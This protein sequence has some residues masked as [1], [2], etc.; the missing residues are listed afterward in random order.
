[1][2]ITDTKQVPFIDRIDELEI[3]NRTFQDWDSCYTVF[4]QGEGG[5]GKTRFVREAVQR[6]RDRLGSSLSVS[7]EEQ[8]IRIGT[9]ALTG[10]TGWG[11]LFL[12]GCREMAKDLGVQLIERDAKNDLN[13]MTIC[14][15]SLMQEHPQAVIIDLGRGA[16]LQEA[17]NKAIRQGIHVITV[18]SDLAGDQLVEIAQNEMQMALHS[19][20]PMI[21]DLDGEGNILVCWNPG[22]APLE[23]RRKMLDEV[24]KRYPKIRI[25]AEI[26]LRAGGK[27][28]PEEAD[29]E[30]DFSGQI[31]DALRAQPDVQAIWASSGEYGLA[32]VKALEITGRSDI[33]LYS[34]DFDDRIERLMRRP[35]SPWQITVASNPQ[36]IGKIAIRVAAQAV[37]GE[38]LRSRYFTPFNVISQEMVQTVA[39]MQSGSLPGWEDG[40]GVGWSPWLREIAEKRGSKLE[41]GLRSELLRSDESGQSWLFLNILDLDDARLHF[42][43]DLAIALVNQLG[44]EHFRAYTEA[45]QTLRAI[46][47][48]NPSQY[49]AQ[50]KV[51]DELFLQTLGRLSFG[52]RTVMICDTTDALKTEQKESIVKYLLRITNYL[53]NTVMIIAGRD[54][55]SFKAEFD[56]THDLVRT[57]LIELK[58]FG[59]EVSKEYFDIKQRKLGVQ[60]GLE[61]EEIRKIVL[62]SRGLPI[63]IDLAMEWLSRGLARTWLTQDSLEHLV[64][65][66]EAELEERRANF[67]DQLVRPIERLTRQLDRLAL[68][69]A[70]VKPMDAELCAH[71]IKIPLE[72]ADKLV[73]E[74][75]ELSFIKVLPDQRIKLHDYV[76][77]MIL[78]HVWPD[79]EFDRRQYTSELAAEYYDRRM[80]HLREKIS[81]LS[82]AD[83]EKNALLREYWQAGADRVF[84]T[85]YAE[86][87]AG[88]EMF[89]RLFD[90]ATR[91]YRIRLRENLVEVASANLDML[92]VAQKYPVLRRKIRHLVDT[93]DYREARTIAKRYLGSSGNFQAENREGYIDILTQLANC[94]RILGNL[95]ES[96]AEFLRAY[97]LCKRDP[98][99]A[100]ITPRMETNIGQLLRLMGNLDEAEEYYKLAQQKTNDPA[101]IASIMNNFG[102]VVMLQGNFNRAI[103]YCREGLELREQ[104]HLEREI[105][106]SHLTLG[107][108]YRNWAKYDDALQEYGLALPIFE[109]EQDV[110]WLSQ[111]NVHLGS[112]YRILG[113]L[114]EAFTYLSKSQS[115]RVPIQD[116]YVYHAL[117]CLLWDKGEKVQALQQL[118]FSDRAA[119]QLDLNQVYANNLLVGAEILY[120]IWVESDYQDTQTLAAIHE[121]AQQFLETSPQGFFHHHARMDRVEADTYFD[122]QNY[123]TAKDL[124][125]RA[126]KFLGLRKGGYGRRTFDDELQSLETRIVDRL[127]RTNQDLAIQ[128][129]QD[130]RERWK[131]VSANTPMPWKDDLLD[132]CDRCER[133]L[134]LAALRSN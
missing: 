67:E 82:D 26:G 76:Q 48:K 131:N 89:A 8:A 12:H 51:V 24:I 126:Y 33:H 1:M 53:S 92:T 3:M 74:A 91:D 102:Y 120:D 112:T 25:A 47:I 11:K 113:K 75:K 108:I 65:L 4:V 123:E 110:Y 55:G 105:G 118:I 107:E 132:L 60:L 27:D 16:A 99:L 130:L 78:K 18:S 30:A 98:T 79:I 45:L 109:R 127:G 104:L 84:H 121:K 114:E 20:Q 62:L 80:Q 31:V 29:Q 83:V 2:S 128:W 87:S 134:R 32:A 72:D 85:F 35:H 81:V 64:S 101:L 122:E 68:A 23:E 41:S 50:R 70:W 90:E 115:Y 6:L 111:V 61:E 38:N 88:V 103:H 19:L 97:D 10:N 95:Q 71:L 100:H 21:E 9:L 46:E 34:I 124:Y 36:E 59:E 86:S 119:A 37:Y 77:E 44:G 96:H 42:P 94:N 63:Q 49:E 5:V 52:H 54:A 40:S 73:N 28:V 13:E 117:A 66:D 39:G 14:F 22:P 15:G 69:L 129:C 133:K 106:I 93:G 17:V 58:P 116:P 56:R 7:H 57:V 125:F 43:Q